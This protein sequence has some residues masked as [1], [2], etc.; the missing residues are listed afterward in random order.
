[1]DSVLKTLNA[2][3]F[4]Y[5]GIYIDAFKNLDGELKKRALLPNGW[6]SIDNVNMT[7]VWDKNYGISR[8]PNAVAIN[9]E[10]SNITTIDVDKPN[11]C[12]ILDD[13][14]NECKFMLRLKRGI[15]SILRKM[16]K[17]QDVKCVVLQISIHT[18]YIYVLNIKNSNLII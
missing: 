17:Y 18:Y 6:D 11:E 4:V 9:T 15:T 8:K 2:Y 12:E 5:F 1:M 3:N 10:L 16:T 14:L 7:N 13:L